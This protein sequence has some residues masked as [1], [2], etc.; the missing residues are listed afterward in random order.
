MN[1]SEWINRWKSRLRFSRAHIWLSIILA[2]AFLLRLHH[3]DQPFIDAFSWRQSS[4]AMMAENFFVKGNSI[5]YP[6]VNWTGS[7]TG[8]QGREFQTIS[9]LAA[10]V[11]RLVRQQDWVGRGMAI[12]FGLWGIF[13]LYHLVR[14]VWDEERAI[15]SAAIMAILPGSIFIERSFLPDPAMVALV[16]T[17]LWLSVAYLQENRRRYLILAILIGALGFMTKLPGL[18]VGFPLIYAAIILGRKRGLELAIATVLTLLPVGLYYLWARHLALTYPPHHFAGYGHWL[19]DDGIQAWLQQSYFLPQLWHHITVWLWSA[20][21]TLTAL[22]GLG[23]PVHAAT[24]FLPSEVLPLE[25][26]THNVPIKLPY[27][28]HVWFLAFGIYYL[29]GASELVNNPW[30]LHIATPAIAALSAHTLVSA[31]NLINRW[32]RYPAPLSLLLAALVTLAIVTQTGLQYMYKPYAYQGYQLGLGLQKISQKGD[33]VVTITKDLG[34]PVAIYYS[35]RRGWIFP[36]LL[37]HEIDGRLPSDAASIRYLEELR[38]RGASWLGIVREQHHEI[39]QQHPSLK[40]YIE[41]TYEIKRQ[42]SNAVIYS[43]KR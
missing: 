32:E 12:A 2:I 7:E 41:R 1:M 22:I 17:S 8:Y 30:N 3:I 4:T 37:P 23:L 16:T 20:P 19:W 35:H 40:A 15:A 14:R 13:A 26:N 11:Y 43:A 24:V 42:D 25:N 21:F 36:P 6:E 33:L 31:A 29:I 27:F 34:D 9:Y 38:S 39:W 5:F 18:I 28:C 10:L